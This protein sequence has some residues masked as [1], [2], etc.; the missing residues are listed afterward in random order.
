MSTSL[1]SVDIV[2]KQ[3]LIKE[4]RISKHLHNKDPLVP[5]CDSDTTRRLYH[6]EPLVRQVEIYTKVT[7]PAVCTTQSRQQLHGTLKCS[8]KSDMT[9]LPQRSRGGDLSAVF[10]IIDH[11]FL[12]KRFSSQFEITDSTLPWLK[13][14]LSP[15]LFSALASGFTL[16]I[17]FSHQWRIFSTQFS[18]SSI[19]CTS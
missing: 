5:Y 6:T 2:N 4:T 18:S 16:P 7:R 12:F 11:S 8:G 13:T 14:C 15:H 17:L 3:R 10:E 19:I 1:C 9:R